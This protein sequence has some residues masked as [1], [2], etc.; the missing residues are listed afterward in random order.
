[1]PVKNYTVHNPTHHRLFSQ[2]QHLP[3]Y[4][5]KALILATYTTEESYHLRSKANHKMMQTNLN[6]QSLKTDEQNLSRL[7]STPIFTPS[8]LG[9]KQRMKTALGKNP[10]LLPENCFR[11]SVPDYGTMQN[12]IP[13]L[14]Q[15]FCQREF[16]C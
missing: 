4:L 15:A 10:C 8:T 11:D 13:V 2:S 6:I 16:C 14:E 9:S 1:M 7:F 12:T 5:L 3:T